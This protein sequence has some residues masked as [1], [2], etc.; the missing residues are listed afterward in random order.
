LTVFTAHWASRAETT[1]SEL[2]RYVLTSLVLI[3]NVAVALAP[4]VIGLLALA[5]ALR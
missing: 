3:L 5:G 2:R 1:P 4:A